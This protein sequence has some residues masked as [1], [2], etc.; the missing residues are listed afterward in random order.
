[1]SKLGTV[2]GGRCGGASGAL[3]RE[4]APKGPDYRVLDLRDPDSPA[5]QA[6]QRR[7]AAVADAAGDDEIEM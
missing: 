6:A 3:P 7:D 5:C 1:M 4:D 2:P